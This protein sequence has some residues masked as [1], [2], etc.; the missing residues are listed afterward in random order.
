[1]YVL[2]I[3]LFYYFIFKNKKNKKIY[4]SLQKKSSGKFF[5]I[6]PEKKLNLKNK[7]DND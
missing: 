3:H 5:I 4:C 6:F 2:H 7:L 1:M